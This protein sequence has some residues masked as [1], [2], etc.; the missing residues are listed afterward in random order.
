MTPIV[1]NLPFKPIAFRFR[2]VAH[3]M[4]RRIGT[5]VIDNFQYSL[6]EQNEKYSKN[7]C[8]FYDFWNIHKNI[9]FS[10]LFVSFSAA[11]ELSFTIP[12]KSIEVA[13]P[14]P[15]TPSSIL[16]LAPPS[17]LVPAPTTL[18]PLTPPRILQLFRKI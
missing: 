15:P 3:S 5:K 4:H 13:P 2:E 7:W 12:L 1:L 11:A 10:L 18:T 8:E 9:T 14:E 6:I 17:A 16:V